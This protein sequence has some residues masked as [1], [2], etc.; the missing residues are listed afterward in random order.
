M[1]FHLSSRYIFTLQG[2]NISLQNCILKMMFLF[3]SWDMLIP[4]RVYIYIYILGYIYIYISTFFMVEMLNL[5]VELVG[6]SNQLVCEKGV[7]IIA[8]SLTAKFVPIAFWC[9]GLQI[10]SMFLF[11]LSTYLAMLVLLHGTE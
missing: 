9:S 1:C 4:L 7:A 11:Q 8:P 2:T 3:P 10:P 5:G 6:D